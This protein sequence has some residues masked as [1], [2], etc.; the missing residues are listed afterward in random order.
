[1]PV[2]IKNSLAFSCVLTFIVLPFLTV[3]LVFYH[4]FSGEGRVRFLFNTISLN[5]QD[6]ASFTFSLDPSY[7]LLMAITFLLTFSIVWIIYRIKP[8]RS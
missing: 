4:L 6:N 2:S 5:V 7:F 1:M 8:S 3:G